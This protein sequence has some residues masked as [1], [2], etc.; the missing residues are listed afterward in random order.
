MDQT[1]LNKIGMGHI[2][3]TLSVIHGELTQD[4]LAYDESLIMAMDEILVNNMCQDDYFA[5]HT[6]HRVLRHYEYVYSLG[7]RVARQHL[8]KLL[9]NRDWSFELKH[10]DHGYLIDIY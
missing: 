6:D 4:P 10:T 2:D 1:V 3:F 8:A 7:R 9:R 5:F